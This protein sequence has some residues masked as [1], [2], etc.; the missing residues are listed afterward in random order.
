MPWTSASP[1]GN[2]SVRANRTTMNQNTAYIET[3]MGNSVV[4]TNTTS[5]RDHFWNV[6]SNEDG[7]HRFIQS[8]GFTVGGNPEDP[9]VG[10]GMDG[11]M[12]LKT[13]SA[14]IARVEGFYRNAQGIYQFIP[15][16]LS[17]TADFTSSGSNY[18]TVVS[19]PQNTYGEIFMYTT[20]PIASTKFGTTTGYFRSNTLRVQSWT[21]PQSVDGSSTLAVPLKFGNGSEASGFNIRARR[22]DSD[23]AS[24]WNYRIIYRA[25]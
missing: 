16:F 8:V 3:T 7:R 6:G 5:T 9:V 13:A 20:D 2:I 22:E 18:I 19:V 24:V 21:L 12:Y 14:D 23:S 17:G 4:G 15:S 10:T 25:L 11:V 1:I